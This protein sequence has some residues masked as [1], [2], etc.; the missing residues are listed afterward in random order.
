MSNVRNNRP[1][2]PPATPQGQR[3]LPPA[4][5]TTASKTQPSQA[6]EVKTQP[7]NSPSAQGNK[8]PAAPNGGFNPNITGQATSISRESKNVQGGR[9]VSVSRQTA[10]NKGGVQ[11]TDTTFTPSKTSKTPG[12][13]TIGQTGANERTEGTQGKNRSLG[14][15]LSVTFK[16]ESIKRWGVQKDGNL[17]DKTLAKSKDGKTT[18]SAQATGPYAEVKYAAKAGVN[19]DGLYADVSLKVDAQAV[20]GQVELNHTVEVKKGNDTIKV[21]LK[22]KL[23]GNIGADGE[24]KLRINVSPKAPP[25]I[26]VGASGFAGAKAKLSGTVGVSVNDKMVAEGELSGTLGVGA[27]GEASA[28]MNFLTGEFSAKAYG[29]VGVGFG[30]SLEGK[31]YY[32]NT[33]SAIR[34][35]TN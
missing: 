14:K 12:Q 34:D 7:Q 3:A 28:K 29:A 30:A 1:A 13:R 35:L 4:G 31:V 33:I 20:K 19:Q 16:D 5:G 32:G 18:L 26:E 24:L 21:H 2:L 6:K 9:E 11:R 8:R 25:S 10:G 15:D 23:E 17:Y 22:G 27:G